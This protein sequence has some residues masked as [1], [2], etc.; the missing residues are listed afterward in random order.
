MEHGDAEVEDPD[1][2][3]QAQKE[4]DR[5]ESPNH[6]NPEILSKSALARHSVVADA[7]LLVFRENQRWAYSCHQLFEFA[8]GKKPE[9]TLLVKMCDDGAG[10]HGENDHQSN[11]GGNVNNESPPVSQPVWAREDR[12]LRR[13]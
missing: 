7:S 13:R 4:C 3:H 10:N 11:D 1:G 12:V 9:R 6:A 8:N 2:S 5:R